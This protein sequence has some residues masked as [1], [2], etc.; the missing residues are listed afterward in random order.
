MT[1]RRRKTAERGYGGRW[2]RERLL[3]L[4]QHPLCSMC[5]AEGRI[6]VATV[7]DHITPHRGDAG[8]MW[9]WSNW[10]SLCKPHHDRDKQALDKGGTP[11][12]PIGLDGWPL[13]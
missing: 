7:V 1:E 6:T 12:R 5:E 10:Q 2:Q 11:R 13:S 4:N 8:L 3:F 9:D